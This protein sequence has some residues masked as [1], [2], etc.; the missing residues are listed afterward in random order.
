VWLTR[1]IPETGGGKLAVMSGQTL[2][3]ADTAAA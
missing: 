3:R 1:S 2:V